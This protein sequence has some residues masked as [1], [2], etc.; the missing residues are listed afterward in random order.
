MSGSSTWPR[1]QIAALATTMVVGGLAMVAVRAAPAPTE[2]PQADPTRTIRDGVYTV[3]QAARGRQLY[4]AICIRCHGED[5]LGANAR[6]L[7]GD[8]FIRDWGGL[9]LDHFY[10]RAKTMPPG[11][12]A[13]LAD[14]E[15]LDVVTYVLEVNAVPAGE[16]ELET[17]MLPDIMVE[18]EGGPDE[19]PDFSLVHVV[20]C[21]MRGP[22]GDWLLSGASDPV[23][24]RDPAA[25]AGDALAEADGTAL[26]SGSFRLMY[27]F[28][29]PAAYEGHRVETKGF[30][31]R[32]P[33]DALN[34]TVVATLSATCAAP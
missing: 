18:G 29:D 11:A 34:V 13:R 26:G 24:T 31:I 27:V 7:A 17:H 2:V 1:A 28:P 21:L 30:L 6:P 23:R 14:D 20:G 4:E 12:A 3:E 15:Y 5:L 22:D 32:G 9:T 8:A 10:E 16:A 25:S 33:Q 19:V